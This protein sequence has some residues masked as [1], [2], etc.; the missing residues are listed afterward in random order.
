[1]ALTYFSPYLRSPNTQG[2]LRSTTVVNTYVCEGKTPNSD[3]MKLITRN[4][5]MLSCGCDPPESPTAAGSIFADGEPSVYGL[6]PAK[7]HMP[8]GGFALNCG[9]F[10]VP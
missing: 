7:A 1:M 5:I 6:F 4:G 2:T 9:V 10:E 3:R 8:P